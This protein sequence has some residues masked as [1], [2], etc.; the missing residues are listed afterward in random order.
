MYDNGTLVGST[1]SMPNGQWSARIALH[2]PYTSSLHDL[3][4][5]VVTQD[6]KR[7]LTPIAHGGL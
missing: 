5:E 7:L 6:G 2:K 3:Y 1:Y 4:A